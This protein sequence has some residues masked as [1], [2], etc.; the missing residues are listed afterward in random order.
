MMK[1]ELT[2]WV[3]FALIPR[4]WTKRK[5]EIY[6]KCFTH[7]PRISIVQL[8]ED[9][10]L[11]HELGL[12]D[13]ECEMLA[14]A[15]MQ[16]PNNSFLVEDLLSQG[17]RIEPVDSKF[18]SPTLKTNLK[19][20]SPVVLFTKGN[21][22]LLK[23]PTVAIVGSRKASDVSLKF[24]ADIAS[25]EATSGKVV[26]SGFA[27]GVDR[28]ALDAALEAGGESIIVLPQGITTFTN[29]YREYYKYISMGKVLVVS[30]FAPKAPW[31]V[32]LAMAR[33]PIIYGLSDEI[34]VAQSSDKGGTWSG[35]IDGLR[36]KRKIYVRYSNKESDNANLLLIQRGAIPVDMTGCQLSL[37]ENELLTPEEHERRQQANDIVRIITTGQKTSQEIAKLLQYQYSDAKMKNILRKMEKVEEVK[38]K[39]KVYFRLRGNAQQTLF[40]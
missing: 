1:Q 20:G 25:K 33:N 27:K 4:M 12:T 40:S 28:M 36:K 2:Y 18:Y 37:C 21:V 31:S 35:V 19:Q 3:T 24:T 34:Y 9:S 29:G 14:S 38:I 7:I 32:E 8:F 30:P 26:V 16:L 11:W 10:S 13:D 15:K 22:D 39:N 23:K 6:A 17:Y 5:N